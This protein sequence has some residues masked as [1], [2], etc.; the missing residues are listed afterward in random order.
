MS[1]DN[2]QPLR[3]STAFICRV[4]VVSN[5][6][7]PGSAT[8]LSSGQSVLAGPADGAPKEPGRGSEAILHRKRSK[9]KRGRMRLRTVFLLLALLALLTSPALYFIGG[10]QESQHQ[11]DPDAAK[12]RERLQTASLTSEVTAVP[13]VAATVERREI[14]EYLFGIGTV[15]AFRTVT[16]HS[17][18]DGQ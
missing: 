6:L 8:A 11:A 15:Q 5:G 10:S 7:F 18:V 4:T 2:E 1:M 12:F 13:I 3:L 17:R 16:V 9:L 14:P